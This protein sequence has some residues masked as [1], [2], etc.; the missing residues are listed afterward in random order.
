VQHEQC[1]ANA[2]PIGDAIPT[3]S[4]ALPQFKMPNPIDR[5]GQLP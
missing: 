4:V 1:V 2:K 5:I 3:I